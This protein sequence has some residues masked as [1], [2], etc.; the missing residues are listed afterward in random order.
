MQTTRS[1]TPTLGAS[2]RVLK[3]ELVQHHCLKCD[4]GIWMALMYQVSKNWRDPW[5]YVNAKQ[6][7]CPTCGELRCD[8]EL[9]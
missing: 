3:Q 7:F 2:G 9:I 5:A 4:Q 8:E 1:F 6:R